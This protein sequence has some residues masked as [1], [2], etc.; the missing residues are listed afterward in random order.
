[1][2]PKCPKSWGKTAAQSFCSYF[3]SLYQEAVLT[4]HLLLEF[5]V[6]MAALLEQIESGTSLFAVVPGTEPSMV[7]SLER[8]GR[9]EIGRDNGCGSGAEPSDLDSCGTQVGTLPQDCS[10]KQI[11]QWGW[12]YFVDH[13]P[14]YKDKGLFLILSIY[15]CSIVNVIRA[16]K[17]DKIHCWPQGE[18][19]SPFLFFS[20]LGESLSIV[21]SKPALRKG[22]DIDLSHHNVNLNTGG[23]FILH[24]IPDWRT[25]GFVY[26]KINIKHWWGVDHEVHPSGL[27]CRLL[28]AMEP[29]CHLHRWPLHHQGVF[30]LVSDSPFFYS[31]T[32]FTHFSSE[33]SRRQVL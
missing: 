15:Y 33:F 29:R 14:L 13:L 3:P 5:S 32:I 4:P 21:L 31:S 19:F 28:P 26:F 9:M 24:V 27:S 11:R 1:M 8:F 6:H 20:S 17:W 25:K 2:G 23:I 12:R 10:G 30:F 7:G 16:K 22:L 18:T